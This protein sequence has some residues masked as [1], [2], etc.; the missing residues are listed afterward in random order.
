MSAL[1][2]SLRV[3][4]ADTFAMYLKAHN[5]HWNVEGPDF[6]EYHGFL[7]TLYNELWGAVDAIAEHIR[8]LDEYSPGSFGRFSDLT[9]IQDAITIPSGVAMFTIL[10]GDN[11][12]VLKSLQNAYALAE[13]EKEI[14]LSNF[15]QDRTDTHKKHGWMLRATV[16]N[17]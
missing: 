3:V 11:E 2:D 6:F 15:L 8:A 17:R 16:K 4:L 12:I 9:S 5:Y 13:K 7:D 10:M 1:G 14:G